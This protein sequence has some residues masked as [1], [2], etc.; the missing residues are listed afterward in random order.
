[1]LTASFILI[2]SP[3]PATSLFHNA[4]PFTRSLILPSGYVN[5]TP[6]YPPF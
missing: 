2:S 1:L 6:L 4:T 3:L 5:L